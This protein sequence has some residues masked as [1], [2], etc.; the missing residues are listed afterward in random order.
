MKPAPLG[1]ATSATYDIT[2]VELERTVDSWNLFREA[3]YLYVLDSKGSHEI[4]GKF[5]DQLLAKDQLPPVLRLKVLVLL[6]SLE[7][8]TSTIDKHISEA[9]S[10]YATTIKFHP[11]G[12]NADADAM[13]EEIRSDIDI[14][15]DN[16]KEWSYDL[17]DPHPDYY[18]LHNDHS[19]YD[20][21]QLY[22]MP[23]GSARVEHATADTN[24]DTSGEETSDSD[25]S[26][27]DND[28]GGGD[29]GGGDDGGGGDEGG[30][31]DGGGDG[32]GGDEGEEEKV[33][34]SVYDTF[35]PIPTGKYPTFQTASALAKSG[36]LSPYQ[37]YDAEKEHKAEEAKVVKDPI[38][39]AK[40][41]AR[42]EIIL[43]TEQRL[44]EKGL[45]K[46]DETILD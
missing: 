18:T 21:E 13:L 27:N 25:A 20:K 6:M 7:N 4:A 43:A 40:L 45:I 23:T 22:R 26:D 14:F 38:L 10:L 11:K 33:Q 3:Q 34:S 29:D 36:A 24:E 28:N 15:I 12:Q 19:F 41:A 5:C 31:D 30:G 39:E 16:Q 35:I 44:K 9:V 8:D 37:P 1:F 42:R 17:V 32:G 46:D 2:D